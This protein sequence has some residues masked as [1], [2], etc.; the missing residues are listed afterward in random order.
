MFFDVVQPEKNNL[1][2]LL[3]SGTLSF[4]F[5]SD[6]EKIITNCGASESMGK[7]PEFLRYSAAHS[8]IILQNTNI[9]EI[10]EKIQLLILHIMYHS[11]KRTRKDIQFCRA[12][13]MVTLRDLIK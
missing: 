5:S 13:I 6:G 9:R 1:N 12:L 4:E 3:S 11:I 10:K 7:N 8:T 2:N